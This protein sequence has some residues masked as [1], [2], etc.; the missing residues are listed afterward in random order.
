M[1]LV[2][3]CSEC[4]SKLVTGGL[5]EIQVP[6]YRAIARIFF[7]PDQQTGIHGLA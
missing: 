4:Y 2:R 7:E 1:A 3:S 6:V 5:P